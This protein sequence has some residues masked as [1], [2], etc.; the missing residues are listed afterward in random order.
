VEPNGDVEGY[1]KFF[2]EVE[3]TLRR[4]AFL[5]TGNIDQACDL[6]QETLVRAWQHWPKVSRHPHPDAWCCTV[7]HNLARSRWRRAALERSRST[8]KS[9]QT[10]GPNADHLDIVAA[11]RRLPANQQQAIILHD[12][13]GYTAD[14][15]AVEL[16][17]SPGTVR[18]WLSRGRETL[19][20]DLGDRLP[21]QAK[22]GRT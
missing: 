7:L 6:A 16:H 9:G 10:S 2:R 3:P 20:H 5:H 1:E 19:W 4:V 13:V 12:I 22:G 21:E 17:T 15:I 18:S 14:E 8:D 11:L